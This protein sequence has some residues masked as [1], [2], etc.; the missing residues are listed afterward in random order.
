MKFAFIAA[1]EVAFL[2]HRPASLFHR[3][4]QSNRVRIA[5]PHRRVCGIVPLS[6][7]PGEDHSRVAGGWCRRRWLDWW[8]G[9]GRAIGA[10]TGPGDVS[11]S[12]LRARRR[13]SP[14]TL[15]TGV[16]LSG[17]G[18]ARQLPWASESPGCAPDCR[19]RLGKVRLSSICAILSSWATT[20][21]PAAAK[22][23][24]TSSK[25]RGTR[26]RIIGPHG[27]CLC[28]R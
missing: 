1:K 2:Q 24:P 4:R 11:G 20:E 8:S 25:R 10:A 15:A 21:K 27:D 17:N 23:G 19:A 26:S 7:A 22:R 13:L 12:H 5:V 3:L 28:R 9:Q 6:T 16:L 14:A 18:F